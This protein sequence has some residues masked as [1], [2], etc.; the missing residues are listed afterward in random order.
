MAYFKIGDTDY[1]NCVNELKVTKDV[2][3]TA[4]TNAA[5][6]TVV[7]YMNKKRT[8]EVGVI[9][10]KSAEMIGLQQA[11]DSFSVS[12]SFM[13]PLTNTLEENVSCII[14]SDTVE[15]YTIHADGAMFKAFN[16]KFIEL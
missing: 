13:N 11:I 10:L 4:Q 9:P 1:S 5:G 12:V 6:D 3:Y 8:I 2:N 14:P 16:L 7:D 15:Y